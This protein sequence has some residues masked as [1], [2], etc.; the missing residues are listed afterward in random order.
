MCARVTDVM[1][2]DVIT[3][4]A[5]TS[6]EAVAERMLR[7]GIGSVVIT[8][9]G[10]SYGIVTE[11]DIVLATYKTG[12]PLAEIPTQ[13]VASHPVV[14][15]E[16]TQTLRLAATRMRDEEIKKLV[17]VSGLEIEGILTTQDLIDHYGEL[18]KDI[19][20]IRQRSQPRREKWPR[21]DF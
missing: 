17:V 20:Q 2:E 5:D 15:V 4:G 9:D 6:L 11:T 3:C 13:A 8:T 14:T 19:Q 7:N 10:N 1:T 16:P 18:T 21:E 12:K